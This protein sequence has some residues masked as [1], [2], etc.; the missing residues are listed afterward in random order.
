VEKQL[1]VWGEIWFLKHIKR[2]T[3]G[4]KTEGVLFG[5]FSFDNQTQMGQEN[6]LK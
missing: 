5:Q 3:K 4:G 2:K 1:V 6:K